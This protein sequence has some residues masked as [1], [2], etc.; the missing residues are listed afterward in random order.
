MSRSHLA[1][2]IPRQQVFNVTLFV[3]VNDGSEDACDVGVRLY[4]I[5]VTGFDQGCEH[6]PVLGTGF[7]SYEQGVFAV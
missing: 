1:L 5:Q 4:C 3:P 6:G 2:K 7:V